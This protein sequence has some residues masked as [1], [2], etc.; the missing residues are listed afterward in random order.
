MTYLHTNNLK[1]KIMVM[2]RIFDM[3]STIKKATIE[4]DYEDYISLMSILIDSIYHSEQSEDA[5]LLKDEIDESECKFI[6][7][8]EDV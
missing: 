1:R 2:K 6:W 8:D 5:R 3:R 7:T 4:M